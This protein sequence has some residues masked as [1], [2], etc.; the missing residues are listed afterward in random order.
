MGSSELG[1]III[2]AVAAG[3]AA[4]LIVLLAALLRHTVR[5]FRNGDKLYAWL[6][7]IRWFVLLGLS[8][9]LFIHIAKLVKP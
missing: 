4:G 9:L 1:W 5:A 8:I 7:L 2:W 3:I 6:S